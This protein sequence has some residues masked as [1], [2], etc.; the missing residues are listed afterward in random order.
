MKTLFSF[1]AALH[2]VHQGFIWKVHQ[3]HVDLHELKQYFKRPRSKPSEYE[4]GVLK[5]ELNKNEYILFNRFR[6]V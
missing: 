1:G 3:I 6:L 2:T 4:L 5:N